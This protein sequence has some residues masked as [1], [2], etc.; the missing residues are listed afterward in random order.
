[1]E[2]THRFL[3]ERKNRGSR[4]AELAKDEGKMLEDEKYEIFKEDSNDDDFNPDDLKNADLNSSSY[5]DNEEEEGEEEE[6]DENEE[7]ESDEE[8]AEEIKKK[9][10]KEK[11]DKK[12]KK[13]KKEEILDIDQLDIDKIDMIEDFRDKG[14]DIDVDDEEELEKRMR[15]YNEESE[16]EESEKENKKKFGKKKKDIKKRGRKKLEKIDDNIFLDN[17]TPE[18]D[19]ILNKQ[20]ESDN[21]NNNAE[22]LNGKIIIS[23]PEFEE[24][25]NMELEGENQSKKEQESDYDNTSKTKKL[26]K[27]KNKIKIKINQEKEEANLNKNSNK[28]VIIDENNNII[29]NKSC[30]TEILFPNGNPKLEYIELN[31]NV[32]NI[33]NVGKTRKSKMNSKP[34][35]K[36]IISINY[37]SIV[38]NKSIDKDFMPKGEEKKK[39]NKV[40]NDDEEEINENNKINKINNNISNELI[41]HKRTRY[42]NNLIELFKKQKKAK[43][44]K[45]V[46][47]VGNRENPKYIYISKKIYDEN[48]EEKELIK[49]EKKK[50]KK[51]KEKIKDEENENETINFDLEQETDTKNIIKKY[52]QQ[53]RDKK[54]FGIQNKVISQEQRLLESIFTELTNKQSLKT[55]Q[56]LEDLN[57]REYTTT[58][59][60]ILKDS[61]KIINSQRHIIEAEKEKQNNNTEKKDSDKDKNADLNK[62]QII[63]IKITDIKNIKTTTEE[64]PKEEKENIENKD[65]GMDIEEIKKEENIEKKEEIKNIEKDEDKEKEIKEQKE[66]EKEEENKKLIEEYKQKEKKLNKITVTFANKEYFRNLFASMNKKPIKDK[67]EKICII[68]GKPAKYFDPLTKNYYATVEAFKIL[69]ERYFQKEEDCLLFKIQ[70]LSD[71]ASQKKERL[72]KMIMQESEKPI[73]QTEFSLENNSNNNIGINRKSNSI[74]IDSETMTLEEQ[75]EPVPKSGVNSTLLKMINKFGLLRKDAGVEEKKTISHRIYNRNRENCVESGMLLEANKYKLII[76]KKIFKDKYSSK[77]PSA[78]EANNDNLNNINASN[79]KRGE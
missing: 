18:T 62:K 44:N 7:E 75:E 69:R 61:I 1:M 76:S 6:D 73:G 51:E 72:K 37:H 43:I 52:K 71:L 15:E 41:G 39:M 35:N 29:I 31:K 79:E 58:S 57:K 55:M 60:K 70:T 30:L 27:Q 32:G 63:E 24:N 45:N 67:K 28:N 16:Y 64:K 68:T 26:K 19:T 46:T 50:K 5:L 53:E 11:K 10:M 66:K 78:N 8:E 42:V 14:I 21:K 13:E 36:N 22:F 47:I 12:D 59:K 65:K 34:D 49:E 56:K 54:Q 3:P 77:L 2:I 20:E 25:N 40:I 33:T 48:D 17:P 9:E 74:R 23:N 4:M 38:I